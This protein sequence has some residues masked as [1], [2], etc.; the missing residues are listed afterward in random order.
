MKDPFDIAKT[1]PLLETKTV[2][3]TDAIVNFT[4]V[5]LPTQKPENLTGMLVANFDYARGVIVK[6][7]TLSCSYCGKKSSSAADLFCLSCGE[8]IDP[9]EIEKVIEEAIAISVPACEDCGAEITHDDIFCMSC[10]SVVL[11]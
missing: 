3:T 2:K 10:G 9:D 5:D 1:A 11:M 7:A 4:P 8:F 6:P